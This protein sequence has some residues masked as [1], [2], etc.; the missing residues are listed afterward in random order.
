MNVH[1]SRPGHC[2]ELFDLNEALVFNRRET[3][4]ALLDA[5]CDII[6]TSPPLLT[7]PLSFNIHTLETADD[8][9][10]KAFEDISFRWKFSFKEERIIQT[11]YN[12][13]Y[14]ESDI[15]HSFYKYG[16]FNGIIALILL[17]RSPQSKSISW[18]P[19]SEAS[20]KWF[21]KRAIKKLPSDIVDWIPQYLHRRRMSA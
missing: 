18:I 8:Q 12:G 9:L 1:F 11:A 4:S 17:S 3:F 19:L 7:A 6:F 20:K 2:E 10:C 16:N 21:V 14:A 13:L 15:E 5:I